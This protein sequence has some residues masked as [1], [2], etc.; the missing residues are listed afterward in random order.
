MHT[1]LI[2]PS[3]SRGILPAK[4]RFIRCIRT[5]AVGINRVYFDLTFIELDV[6][7]PTY[8]LLANDCDQRDDQ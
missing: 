1:G 2:V 4:A 7:V 5:S 8:E 6:T 3:V